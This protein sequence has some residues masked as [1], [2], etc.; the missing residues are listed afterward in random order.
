MGCP[1]LESIGLKHY[2]QITDAGLALIVEGCP[3]LHPRPVATRPK[4]DKFLSTVAASW[5]PNLES[6][7]LAFCHLITDARLALQ[8]G[9]GCLCPNLVSLDLRSCLKTTDAW[10]ASICEGCPNLES[11]DLSF[12]T[13][14]TTCWI[15]NVG[16]ARINEGCTNS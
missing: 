13:A 5:G 15:T 1:N 9:K 14:I 3:K 2:E 7:D 6:L 8:I 11:L 16:V 12:C 10:R 4:G